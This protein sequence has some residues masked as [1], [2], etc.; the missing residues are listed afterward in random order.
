MA[1]HYA[2]AD[3]IS[4]QER[5]VRRRKGGNGAVARQELARALAINPCFHATRVDVARATLDVLRAEGERG[6]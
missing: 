3:S 1:A 5:A 6:Q 2:S 4:P